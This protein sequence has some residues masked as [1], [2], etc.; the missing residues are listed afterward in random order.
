[1]E[2]TKHIDGASVPSK[3]IKATTTRDIDRAPLPP[4]KKKRRRP[5][6][7]TGGA[8]VPPK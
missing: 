1:M 5:E 3:K 6:T 4:Q 7:N 2:T 8:S